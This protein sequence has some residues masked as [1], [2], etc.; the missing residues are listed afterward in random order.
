MVTCDRSGFLGRFIRKLIT[1]CSVI[2]AVVYIY[3]YI[4][5]KDYQTD[6][7][8]EGLLFFMFSFCMI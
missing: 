4:H 3:I 6:N 1:N 2:V 5:I 7:G 8:V